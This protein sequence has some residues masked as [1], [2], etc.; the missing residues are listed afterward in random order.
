MQCGRQRDRKEHTRDHGCAEKEGAGK[1]PLQQGGG[2]GADCRGAGALS[3]SHALGVQKASFRFRKSLGVAGSETGNLLSPRRGLRSFHLGCHPASAAPAAAPRTGFPHAICQTPRELPP[4]L[5]PNGKGVRRGRTPSTS[6]SAVG[7]GDDT[8]ARPNAAS[9]APAALPASAP[10]CSAGLAH[11]LQ[12]AG[13]RT[14]PILQPHPHPAMPSSPL[15]LPPSPG[16][17]CRKEVRGG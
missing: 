2:R 14:P 5:S 1:T 15:P 4:W 6:S 10:D 16:A 17:P 12:Q 13:S 11:D 7:P 8:A 9:P 3:A